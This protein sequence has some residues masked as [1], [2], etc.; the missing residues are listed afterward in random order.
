VLRLLAGGKTNKEIAQELVLSVSTAQR[1]VANIYA[2]IGVHNR[3]EATAYAFRHG[4]DEARPPER[5]PSR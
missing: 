2:K 4:V 5:S 1:H 3:A